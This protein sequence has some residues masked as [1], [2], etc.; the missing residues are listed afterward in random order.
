MESFNILACLYTSADGFEYYL[1][2]NHEDRF[3]RDEAYIIGN[4]TYV[5]NLSISSLDV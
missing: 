1:V 4:Q 5:L 3:S 2:G